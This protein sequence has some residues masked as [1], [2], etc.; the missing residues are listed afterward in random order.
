MYE[1]HSKNGKDIESKPKVLHLI[2]FSLPY[3]SGYSIRSHFILSTQI[4]IAHPYVLTSPY[5]KRKNNIEIIDGV[6]YIHY[7][8][9][10]FT[11]LLYNSRV[12]K[13]F[14][15]SRLY[16]KIYYSTLRIPEGLIQTILKRK[17]IDIIH[18]HSPEKFANLG[19][20]VA[21]EN[22]IPFIYEVRGF[23]EETKVGRGVLTK[24]DPK[25]MKIKLCETMLMRKADAIVTLGEMMKKEIIHRGIDRNKI[26][27]TPNAV[28]TNFFKPMNPNIN[29]KKKLNLLNKT[30]IGYIG[31]IRRIEGI[32]ILVEALK[33]VRKEFDIELLL[34]GNCRRTYR[35]DLEKL[36]E[37]LG[38]SDFIHF[39]NPI[40]INEIINYYSIMELIVI[41]RINTRV[42]RLVTPLKPL[43]AMAMSKVT[44][45]SDLP[46]LLE[47]VI[48]GTSGDIFK[49]GD[50]ND[51]AEKLMYYLSDQEKMDALGK[52]SRKFV[53]ENFSW[54][55]VIEN[56]RILYNKLL[57]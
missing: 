18:G 14:K 22:N 55:S 25:Y 39:I 4:K 35:L 24:K 13:L 42:T 38:L 40:P 28:D 37:K 19:E 12:S 30:L 52:S 7:P 1:P 29:L 10:Y 21:H 51:L 50:P 23:Y 26:F 36:S 17:N 41:P 32:E 11:D 33:E 8:R 57:K 6:C 54:S 45:T 2:K 20:R 43:E 5:Y 16:D 15:I 56:Y 49:A 48:P 47:L 9:N 34:V 3:L 27:I 44:I 31:N 46:A 53:E